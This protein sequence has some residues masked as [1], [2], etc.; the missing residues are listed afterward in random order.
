MRLFKG[1]GL[2][3]KTEKDQAVADAKSAS[4]IPLQPRWLRPD[5]AAQYCGLSRSSLYEEM[6]A[7]NIRSYRVGG[8]RLIDREELDRFISSHPEKSESNQ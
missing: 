1:G 8:C 5:S 4:T 2:M 6:G 7:G 3:L